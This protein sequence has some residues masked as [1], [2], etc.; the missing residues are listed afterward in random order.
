MTDKGE[1]FGVSTFH[2]KLLQNRFLTPNER[3]H[4]RKVVVKITS[5]ACAISIAETF[6]YALHVQYD[7]L[8]FSFS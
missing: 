6:K 5:A 1:P 2:N 8:T 7:P 3:D 4:P